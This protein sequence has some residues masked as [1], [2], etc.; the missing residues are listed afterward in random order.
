MRGKW[1][2]TIQLTLLLVGWVSCGQKKKTEGLP[3]SPV[4]PATIKNSNVVESTTKEELKLRVFS[5]AI[6]YGLVQ[7]E[8]V[9]EVFAAWDV[10]NPK[11]RTKM[12]GIALLMSE[13]DK[14]D[15]AFWDDR[16]N[17]WE[18]RPKCIEDQGRC[19]YVREDFTPSGNLEEKTL[20]GSGSRLMVL[21]HHSRMAAFF[22]KHPK[23]ASLG[24]GELRLQV[25][26]GR[27]ELEAKA[28]NKDAQFRNAIDAAHYWRML[29]INERAR[30]LQGS[31]AAPKFF[32]ALPKSTLAVKKNTILFSMEG[33]CAMVVW[34]L[35]AIHQLYPFLRL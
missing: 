30:F 31:K 24:I 11:K 8:D 15:V 2:K 34:L 5:D 33:D 18:G 1:K 13:E 28:H 12:V 7:P 19:W 16:N 27:I 20:P 35:R 29:A 21:L 4:E 6:G 25:A 17:V 14:I 26:N 23:L 22:E 10:P 3:V 32:E 9:T